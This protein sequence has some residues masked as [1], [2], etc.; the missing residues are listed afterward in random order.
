MIRMPP[1]CRA[2]TLIE[3]LVVIS[4][5]ALLVGILLPAL[6]AARKS[7]QTAVCLSNLRQTGV[8]VHG[9]A[10]DHN[11]ATPPSIVWNFRTDAGQL[12]E[13]AEWSLLIMSYIASSGDGTYTGAPSSAGQTDTSYATLDTFRCP[14][15]AVP[16]GRI[17]YSGHPLTMPLYVTN[18]KQSPSPFM[19]DQVRRSS[20][21][22]LVADANQF[23]TRATDSDA[24]YDLGIVYAAL[25]D[26]DGRTVWRPRSVVK[27]Y[28]Q[29]TETDNDDPI[30]PGANANGVGRSKSI[31]LENKK[32]LRWRHGSGG[33][34]EG[35]TSGSV[36]VLWTD[37]HSDS[38]PMGSITKARVRPD[39]MN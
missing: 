26:L 27:H 33:D 3:L 11:G 2:F 4:I 24:A 5:I 13:N 17:H 30:N 8:G 16:T 18:S 15:A 9:Y 21:N 19:L 23:D 6:S 32:D 35:S 36:N 1:R 39:A 14:S 12:L 10:T 31:A 37:G 20:E 38:N 25:D 34:L 29:P 7:A 28:Y 22:M